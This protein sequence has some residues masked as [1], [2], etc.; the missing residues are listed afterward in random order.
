M[1]KEVVEFLVFKTF[2]LIILDDCK[3]ETAIEHAV[4]SKKVTKELLLINPDNEKHVDH[5]FSQ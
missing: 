1:Q 2:L 3:N 4:D 5:V